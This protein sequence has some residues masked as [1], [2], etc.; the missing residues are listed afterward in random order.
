MYTVVLISAIIF[1][2]FQFCYCVSMLYF[3]FFL[4][5]PLFLFL[6]MWTMGC[7]IFSPS[8]GFKDVSLAHSRDMNRQ[9]HMQAVN[10]KIMQNSGIARWTFIVKNQDT[11]GGK[12]DMR[13]TEAELNMYQSPRFHRKEKKHPRKWE[14]QG[15]KVESQKREF[16][17][18]AGVWRLVNGTCFA[19]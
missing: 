5:R 19:T 2:A 6:P 11:E 15:E 14:G 16:G 3:F 4:T 13:G 10:L 9:R 18:D 8:R 12:C 7:F 17:G 1:H